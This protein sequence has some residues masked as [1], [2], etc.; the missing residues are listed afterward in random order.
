MPKLDT[1]AKTKRDQNKFAYENAKNYQGAVRD[2]C[3]ASDKLGY[4]DLNISQQK[5]GAKRKADVGGVAQRQMHEPKLFYSAFKFLEKW[6]DAGERNHFADFSVLEVEFTD[7]ET[8]RL[9]TNNFADRYNV[10]NGVA[11][12]K[13]GKSIEKKYPTKDE[14]WKAKDNYYLLD[15]PV[16]GKDKRSHSKK[17]EMKELQ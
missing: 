2:N 17:I 7:E 9:A 3:E 13:F 6:E 16:D 10:E 8:A 4:L 15:Y 11:P 1:W 12:I 5:T 14:L